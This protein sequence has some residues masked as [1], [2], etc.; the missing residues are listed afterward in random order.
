MPINKKKAD[1]AKLFNYFYSIS[2]PDYLLQLCFEAL[3]WCYLSTKLWSG[4]NEEEYFS[5]LPLLQRSLY[6]DSQI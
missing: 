4:Q 1:A 2:E 5:P 3:S 6:E